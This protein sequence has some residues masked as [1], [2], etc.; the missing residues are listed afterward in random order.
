MS[1][2]IKKFQKEQFLKSDF[3]KSQRDLINTILEDSVYY[4]KDEVEKMIKKYF[5]EVL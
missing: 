3:Y 4:S 1:K 2:K 5:E